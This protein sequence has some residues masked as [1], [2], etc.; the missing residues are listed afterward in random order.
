MELHGIVGPPTW[1]E[2]DWVGLNLIKLRFSPNSS[3]VFPPFGHLSQLSP[4]YVL[5]VMWLRGRTRKIEW[6]LASWLDLAVPMQ[7]LNSW[8]GSSRLELGVPFGQGFILEFCSRT[9]PMSPQLH[10]RTPYL[11]HVWTSRT[12]TP[13]YYSSM[14]ELFYTTISIAISRVIN[15]KF[16]LQPHPNNTTA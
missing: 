6:F 1:L 3:Q 13:F 5:I 7:G 11:N 14:G 4:S 9:V 16:P 15:F 2:L 8:L 10:L 12:Q